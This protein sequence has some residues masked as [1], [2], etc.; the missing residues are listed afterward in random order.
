MRLI[1]IGL[2]AALALA[3]SGCGGDK[4]AAAT[5]GAE[6]VSANAPVFVAID[7]DLSSNQWRQVDELLRKFPARSQLIEEIRSSLR[8]DA[9]G[10]EYER[11]V[12]PALGDEIDLVWLDFANGGSNV[13]AI[14]K[15]KD[16]DAFRRMIE[17]GNTTGPEQLV[18][19]EMDGWWVLSDTRQKIGRFRQEAES[20]ERLSGSG[21]FKDALGELPDDALV[22]LYV[23]GQSIIDA[24]EN[25]PGF[26]PFR[27]DQRPEFLSAAVS[28]EDSGLRLVG[29]GRAA[30]APKDSI[31]PFESKLLDVV[32]AD[33]VA[34]LTFRGGDPYLR[35]LDDLERNETYRM[36][37]RELERMLGFR[38]S[39]LLELFR[40]E[41]GF[42]VRPGSPI[43]E[44]TLLL[45]ASDDPLALK[46]VNSA[47]DAL[48]KSGGGKRCQAPTT[49]AGVTVSC[50]DL[51]GGIELRT[52]SFEHKVVV[53]TGFGAI[54]KLRGRGPRLADDPGFKS[55]R[56]AA[57]L[58]A[59]SAG[60]M[61]LDLEDG[62]PMI[63]G[64]AAASGASIP[65]EIRSNLEPLGSFL[66]WAETDGRS[67]SFTAFLQI[68]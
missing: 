17:K 42:Y 14:T 61:W 19:E 41:V 43:P 66:A 20:G 27:A 8:E 13:V 51:G 28:A 64:F 52:G 49:E 45:D 7:S 37:V 36:G 6:I 59:E 30:E 39:T 57:G 12:K 50:F 9:G 15:P 3:V 62:I 1:R 33:A 2:L 18:Y 53:T 63:L 38:L 40:N 4:Q 56:D 25:F 23:R 48:T 60:F 55:A 29:A 22:Q 54:S 21:V 47:I 32:P 67:G 24:L 10:L 46:K 26:G 5:G 44:L 16:P 34:F 58:P 31:E 35:Q 68:D 65:A 11:D